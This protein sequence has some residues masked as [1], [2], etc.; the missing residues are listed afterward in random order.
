VEVE[1][2]VLLGEDGDEG[3]AAVAPAGV[4]RHGWRLVDGHERLRAAQHAHAVRRH[5][6]LVAVHVVPAPARRAAVSEARRD[7]A[8]ELR[9]A[10]RSAI[11][12]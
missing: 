12:P 3:V 8:A 4:A 2:R 11:P 7:A 9:S 6:R 10:A 1:E 5:R